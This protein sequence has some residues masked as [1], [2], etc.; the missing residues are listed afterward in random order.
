MKLWKK[1]T[2]SLLAIALSVPCALF[3]ACGDDNGDNNGDNNGN[4][5]NEHSCVYDQQVVSDTYKANGATCEQKA[6]YYYSCT[7]G[8]KGTDTFENGDFAACADNNSDHKCDVC[9]DTLSEHTGGTATET[10]RAICT[11][12]G[13]PYGELKQPE[14][15]EHVCNFNQQVVSD[16]YKANGATCEQKATYYYSC[17]CGAK[18]TDTFE[19][20]DFAA[21]AD[22][23]SDH[24]CDV[25]DDTLSEHTGGTATETERAICT[26]CGQPYGEL[27]QPEDTPNPD[28]TQL[29]APVLTMDAN[30]ARWGE[31]AN[32]SGYL[33]KR[34]ENG[35]EKETD[36]L[37]VTL[38]DGQTLYVKALGDG[39]TYEDSDWAEIT[40]TYTDPYVAPPAWDRR[41]TLST[42]TS[43]NGG[44]FS[45]FE[46]SEGYY[47]IELK[48]NQTHYY[49]FSVP[50]A[51]Q[52]ALV[53]N[54]KK[55]GLTIERCDASTQYIAPTTYPAQTLDNGTL[56]SYVHCS[57]K[58]FNYEWR[59][60]YKIS[61]TT[62]GS[63]VIR[64][65]RVGDALQDPKHNVTNV[66]ATEIVGKAQDKTQAFVATEVPWLVS[67]ATEYFYDENCEMTFIDLT[68]GEEKT[69]KGFY[70]LGTEAN[71]G[72]IIYVAINK[73]P[74]RY[75]GEAFSTIQYKGD[76]LTLYAD[77]D[78]D[79][80]TYSNSYVNFIMNNGGLLDNENGG[81][82][83]VGDPQMLCYMNAANK[84]GL[85]PV[86]QEL[87]DFLNAYVALNKPILDEGV[88]VNEKDYWLA[89]C[90][91]YI[92]EELGSE[93]N[94]IELQIGENT[95]VLSAMTSTYYK[96]A[97][98]SSTAYTFNGSTG[99]IALINGVNYGYGDN[100]FPATIEVSIDDLTN[101][102]LI[103]C[104][105]FDAGEYTLTIT[106]TPIIDVEE[107]DV[108]E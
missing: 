5:G 22:N 20:G 71:P 73:A 56:Y 64:F 10:E 28:L 87:F 90:Y 40:Y 78:V 13:Q 9:D 70:R 42:F 49:S 12:C 105:A 37:Y 75:L 47:E 48:A 91:Y 51:G 23:N 107:E 93:K 81:V 38:L 44:E 86:N 4:G 21:C 27:K 106:E 8:A 33:Y 46:G 39:V 57:N 99:L 98:N 55:T 100:L 69:A 85:F 17:T 65:V 41:P 25:C 103:D 54:T 2:L 72:E 30:V 108:T 11:V 96:L 82:P 26:V 50:S 74:S 101:E 15:G 84:D 61:C 16:T 94:P 18:G 1:C 45:R 7:C 68:T 53:T 79:G 35:K 19:N 92:E 80:N 89:P 88:T 6:T 102:L 66:T 63:I 76:N 32:A 104:K 62:N 83:V 58:Y 34:N 52:Y 67:D 36:G 77:M 43:G 59:A 31:I 29:S 14:D 3:T 60:T 24:K 95:I 97:V